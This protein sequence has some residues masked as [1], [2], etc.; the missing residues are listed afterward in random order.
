MARKNKVQLMPKAKSSLG[1]VHCKCGHVV[2]DHF[3]SGSPIERAA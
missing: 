1:T 3:T 2:T